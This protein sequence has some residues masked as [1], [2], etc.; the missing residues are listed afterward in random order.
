VIHILSPKRARLMRVAA[1]LVCTF[2]LWAVGCYHTW[3]FKGGVGISDSGLFSY[4]RY[5]AQIGR[6]PL[7]KP[8]EYQ[9]TVRGLPPGPLEL[10]IVVQDAM[11]AD[12]AELISL[13]TFVSVSISDSSNNQLCRA[14]GSLSL[15]TDD[16]WIPTPHSFYFWHPR[17]REIQT[18]RFRRYTVKVTVSDVD[19]RSPRWTIMPVLRGGGIDLP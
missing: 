18:S 15:K 8:G 1:L 4:P 7:W 10:G 12:R 17:C 19:A 11:H 9:F 14:T 5:H 2:L 3:E 6:V 13:P 16:P